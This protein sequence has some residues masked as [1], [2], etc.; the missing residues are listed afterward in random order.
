M[1]VMASTPTYKKLSLY[2]GFTT[3]LVAFLVDSTIIVFLYS[4]ILYSASDETMHLLSWKSMIADGFISFKEANFIFR[5]LFYN[6]YFLVLHWF[7]YT[8]FESSPKQATIGKFTLGMKVTDIRGKR[9]NFIQANLRYFAKALSALPFFLG[10]L[11]IMSSRR[12]QMLHDY[13]SKTIIV[14]S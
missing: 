4:I 7:Y 11:L 10:F 12:K 3:R 9:I 5:S 14:F 8:I 2:G 13:I 6:S 1:P